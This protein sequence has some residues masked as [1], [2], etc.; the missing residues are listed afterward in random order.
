MSS[1]SRD[2]G[3]IAV[4]FDE[5]VVQGLPIAAAAEQRISALEA[6]LQA[7]TAELADIDRRFRLLVKSVSDYAIFMLDVKGRVANWNSGAEAIKG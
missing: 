7:R 2:E 5:S 4:L 1:T 3:L 6:Q